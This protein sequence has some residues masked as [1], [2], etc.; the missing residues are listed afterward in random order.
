MI[1]TS[2]GINVLTT[3]FKTLTESL[4]ARQAKVRKEKGQLLQLPG[5]QPQSCLPLTPWFFLMVLYLP[6]LVLSPVLPC[7]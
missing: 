5:A 3:F 2:L 7:L 6:M 1:T 4:L